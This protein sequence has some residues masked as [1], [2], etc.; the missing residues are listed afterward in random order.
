MPKVL[1]LIFEKEISINGYRYSVMPRVIGKSEIKVYF[2]INGNIDPLMLGMLEPIRLGEVTR[3][4][5]REIKIPT[6]W[7]N[8]LL[9]FP[10]DKAVIGLVNGK[11][12]VNHPRPPIRNIPEP[13]I[14]NIPPPPVRN[15][16]EPPVRNIPPPPV[17]NIPPP[18]VRN[19]PP[20]PVRN[21]PPP[22]VRNIPPQPVRN[23]PQPA[24]VVNI[25]E[26]EEEMDTYGPMYRT[27]YIEPAE[28][29][30]NVEEM[31]SICF[32]IH[33]KKDT[34]QTSC[35]HTFGKSCYE[36]FYYAN[37]TRN[38]FCPL[39]RNNY[40]ILCIFITA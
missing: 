16:P 10:C 25:I 1:G 5:V 11:Q 12:M 22:P 15:I 18:P 29:E 6:R 20:P 37:L 7:V 21:I 33:K 23:I 19:I 38:K 24:A 4:I 35:N 30:N 14:R 2:N 13:T 3:Y 31:C 8:V 26:E 34:V 17:R 40:P 39:C 36:S 27:K 28:L 9:P 32:E